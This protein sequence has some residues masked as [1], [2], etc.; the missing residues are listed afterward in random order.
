MSIPVKVKKLTE[1]AHLPTYGSEKAGCADLYADIQKDNQDYILIQPHSTVKIGTGIA[2]QPVFDGYAF[3]I[4]PRS[5]LSSKHGLR[6]A[7]C[8]GY[9][10]EDYTGELIV[11]LHNDSDVPTYVYH[12]DRIA[13]MTI[14]PW[15]KM[16]FKEVNELIETERGSG[17]FGSTGV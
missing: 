13:Q 7:N 3:L 4:Y 15:F 17:G 6:P 5:G 12:G 14:V 9:I 8:V 1:T 2:V 16:E 10:D 11:A